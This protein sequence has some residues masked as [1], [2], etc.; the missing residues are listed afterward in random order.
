MTT[1]NRPWYSD[2]FLR[3][4]L[5]AALWSSNDESTESGG[6]PI[7]ANYGLCDIHPASLVK[8]EAWCNQFQKDNATYLQWAM[9][10]YDVN[11]SQGDSADYAGHDFWLT[12]AGHG[13]GFWDRGFGVRGEALSKASKK[14]EFI[15]CVIGDDGKVHFEGGPKC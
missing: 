2:H 5:V 15:D 3:G 10:R 8:A 4:F 9:D 12:A 11:P 6:E 7:D 13:A 14:Y 1:D